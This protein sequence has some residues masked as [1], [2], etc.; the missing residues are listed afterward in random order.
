MARASE[1]HRIRDIAEIVRDTVPNC[2]LEFAEGAGP[3]T[4][5][6]RVDCSKI[7]RELP[8]FKPEWTV[9]RGARE[10]YNAYQAADLT[11]EAFEGPQFNRIAHVNQLLKEKRLDQNLRWLA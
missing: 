5:N 3:D 2:E 8:E 1:N 6:Y 4:R 10:L 7:G 11:P 9:V